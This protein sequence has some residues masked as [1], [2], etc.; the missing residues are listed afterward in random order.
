MTMDFEID[1]D[2]IDELGSRHPRP[3]EQSRAIGLDAV[4]ESLNRLGVQDLQ[5]RG[6]KLGRSCADTDGEWP[7]ITIQFQGDAR[8]A[9]NSYNEWR[10][11]VMAHA[12][13][14]R[15][16]RASLRGSDGTN[17]QYMDDELQKEYQALWAELPADTTER[18]LKFRS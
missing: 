11:C 6:L 10:E 9:A 7:R 4:V 18:L 13:V 16:L 8:S 1:H 2:R 15:V 14:R 17:H 12:F 3:L 5:Q